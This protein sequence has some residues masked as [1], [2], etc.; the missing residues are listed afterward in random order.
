MTLYI[1]ET[2]MKMADG[3]K[4]EL[5]TQ[6]RDLHMHPE[7]AWTEFRT[8]A[9]VAEQLHDLGYEVLAGEQAVAKE[10]MMGVPSAEVLEQSQAR[11]IREGADPAWVKRMRGGMTG[12]V[13]IM[14]FKQPGPVVGIRF[15]MDCNDVSETQ[16]EK[17]RPNVEGFASL[18]PGA[19]HAC[20][21]DGH[22]TV[23][24]G[25]AK[26]LASLKDELAGT[27][28]LVFQ[29]AEEGVR[30]A[31]AMV[32]RGVVDDVDFMMG[33]HFGFKMKE[34][35]SIACNVTGFLATSKD[36]AHY[37]GKPAHAGAAPEKGKNALLA[38]ACATLN[39]HA[40]SR[41]SQ[42][43]TRINV[44]HLEAGSGRNIIGDTG[45]IKLETRGGSS[46]IN[47]YVEE[48]ALRIIKAAAAMYDVQYRIEQ[49]GGA[50]G[51]SN[52]PKLAA[53]LM[54]QAKS[55]GIFHKIVDK[56]PFG[57][58]EDYS[59]FME[60]VQ[61]HG[62]QAAYMMIGANLAA[63]HHDAHFDF[64]ETALVYSLKMLASSAA[65]L[66]LGQSME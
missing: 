42:G 49:V 41:H 28:K 24:F 25:V 9:L 20:G 38:A 17:H 19:M 50:A 37:I 14:H 22:T 23:G 26:I 43:I 45:L 11:A 2:I 52:S 7:P 31:R 18:H 63:G 36:D 1:Q 62:G 44:G 3:M 66:L 13:G 29:P 51:G 27:I 40:I 60:R 57:A 46:A 15:D 34:T 54:R 53:Y 10:Y 65:G 61:S 16:D 55:L 32:E 35:G 8:A 21:H 5:V 59:Y 39:L 56:C 4:D 12:V 48:E 30:G 64:D 6:R 58:S 47:H 33:A